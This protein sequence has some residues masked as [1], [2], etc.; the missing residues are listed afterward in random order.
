MNWSNTCQI[1]ILYINVHIIG[2]HWY[3]YY[4]FWTST[5]IFIN[6][7]NLALNKIHPVVNLSIR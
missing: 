1:R 3:Q 7:T 6:E 4:L 5:G 2:F